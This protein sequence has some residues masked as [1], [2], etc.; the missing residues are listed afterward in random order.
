MARA[1][2]TWP[3]LRRLPRV[4]ISVLGQEHASICRTL[5]AKGVDRFAHVSWEAAESGAVFIHG[6]A[7]WLECQLAAEFPA[8][9]HDIALLRITRLRTFPE[10]APLVFH[11]S[12]F[13]RLANQV[14]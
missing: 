10:V 5:A 8:G 12:Q 13:C 2:A 7:L 9:D 11:R 4:G 1:S 14:G 6:A 3:L